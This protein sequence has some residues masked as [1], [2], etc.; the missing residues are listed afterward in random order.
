MTETPPPRPAEVEDFLLH[1]RIEKGRATNTLS[2]YSRDLDR[3]LESLDGVSVTAATAKDVQEFTQSLRSAGLK[4]SSINRTMTAV[5]GLHRY[6]FAEGVAD[7]DPTADV[8]PMKL[9]RGLPKA[10]SEQEITSLLEAPDGTDPLATRDRA[11]LEV[12]YGTG[13]RISECTT[14]SLEDVDMAGALLRVTGKGSKQRVV[15]LGRLAGAALERWLAPGGRS[16]LYPERWTD[17][18]AQA[19]VFLNHRGGRLSRQGIWGVV[20]KHALTVGL[21]SKVT[22]HVLRHSCATHMLDHGADIRTV[23]EL[24]GHASVSTTQLYTKVSTDLLVR[25]YRSAHPRAAGRPGGTP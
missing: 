16:A 2:A 20:R 9:P 7:K 13:M 12:L 6:L 17:R 18:D 15:P 11:I 8:E 22:P 3:Y 10:L 21:A 5:R 19:A 25:S 24:L 4:S 14:L 23:Q 1:L